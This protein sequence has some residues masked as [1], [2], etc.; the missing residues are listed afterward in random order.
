[1]VGRY[2]TDNV[3]MSTSSYTV[4]VL[5]RARPVRWW[6]MTSRL[7]RP[8]SIQATSAEHVSLSEVVVN[9]GDGL[10]IKHIGKKLRVL[11]LY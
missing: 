10:S 11:R 6:A 5:R 4:V 1:M 9:I 2:L 3:L 8:A 7:N